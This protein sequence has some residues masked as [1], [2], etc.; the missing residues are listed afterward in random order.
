MAEITYGP[1]RDVVFPVSDAVRIAF[2]GTRRGDARHF[3]DVEAI[4]KQAV[5]LALM[6]REMFGDRVRGIGYA[7]SVVLAH[8]ASPNPSCLD[9]DAE[10]YAR[11]Q[12]WAVERYAPVVCYDGTGVKA[13]FRR[14]FRM[15][16]EFKP[17]VLVAM[18]LA[19]PRA[20]SRGTWHA[21]ECA[22]RLKEC[23]PSLV[24]AVP[25]YR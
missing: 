1:G 17:E 7:L 16:Q 4:L 21:L 18:P 10:K 11:Q 12:N 13:L 3:P 14:T 6:R 9:W 25:D 24:L 20:N 19:G 5:E 23:G 8:G 22:A 2:S 15:I